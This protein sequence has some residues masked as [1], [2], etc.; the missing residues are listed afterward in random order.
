VAAEPELTVVIAADDWAAVAR[1]LGRLASQEDAAAIELLLL[2]PRADE[3]EAA[4]AAAASLWGCR[5]VRAP[6]LESLERARLVG[7][8]EARAPLVAFG[9][10]HSYAEP[11]WARALVDAHRDGWA[12]VGPSVTNANPA[13]AISWAGLFLDYGE[14]LELDEGRETA[15]LPGHNS[16]YKRELLLG[17][18]ERLERLLE[19]E[20]VLQEDL[21][22]QGHRLWLEPRARLAHLNVSRPSDWLAERFW[23]GRFFAA[24][25]S[26][27]WPLARRLLYVAGA[28][29]I[30]FV[31]ARRLLPVRRRCAAKRPL[32]RA[33]GPALAVALVVSALGELVGYVA[34]AG[35]SKAELTRI[36]LYRERYVT[37]ADRASLP[38]AA[39]L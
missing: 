29:L 4:P 22:R 5:A 31:R 3:L 26:R 9:E 21:R 12:A 1:P 18:G 11:G 23:T 17:Y 14:W 7:V 13:A 30:P 8:R 6:D 15:R 24:A 10:T 38:P 28:P 2:S 25:R 16:C 20:L 37:D 33:F 34:G 32:P 35:G 36:E 19:A 39:A 27:G